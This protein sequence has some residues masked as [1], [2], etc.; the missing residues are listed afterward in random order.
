MKSKNSK[1]LFT[2]LLV[3]VLTA[4][5]Y[6][7]GF[8][9]YRWTRS[10]VVKDVLKILE[11]YEKH[12]YFKSDEVVDQIVDAIFDDYSTYYTAEEYAQIK[13]KNNGKNFGVGLSFYT[14][15]LDIYN[16]DVNSPCYKAGVKA[17]GTLL[18]ATTSGVLTNGFEA[19]ETIE[20]LSEGDQVDITIDYGGSVETFSVVK[21]RY[22]LSYVTYMNSI[23]AYVFHEKDNSMQFE[24][25]S[26][27]VISEEGVGY[28][29]LNSF[30][31]KADNSYGV[32]YQ[33]KT[34][35]EKFKQDGNKKLI[36]DLRNNGGGDMEVVSSVGSML[37]KKQQAPQ[38][39]A[40]SEDRNG[41]KKYY[42]LSNNSYGDYGFE[43]II[44]LANI[45]TASASE[46]LIGAMLDYDDDNAV[47]V[48]IDGYTLNGETV[49]KT[50]GKGI[51]QTTYKYPDQS[52]VKVTTA[53][54]F[55]PKSNVSIHGVGITENTSSKVI[56]AVNQSAYSL[57][58]QI[59]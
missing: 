47:Q 6:F 16:V 19:K 42:H 37:V 13:S 32:V 38:Y 22:G 46:M 9:S 18:S 33:M 35:L 49:Y 56:K 57:A 20:N 17:G 11:I 10:S 28:I 59:I 1:R 4:G 54:V 30:S 2:T 36:L 7:L 21:S 40:I 43:K 8:F 24:K 15:T 52:A 25:N 48:I 44:I 14:G 53:K 51:M 58:L 50:Y 55:W 3:L 12:Y 27:A 31:G 39:I 34:A 26:N 5:V 45:N 23:G 41:N 29:K